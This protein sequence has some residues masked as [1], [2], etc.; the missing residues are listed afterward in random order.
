MPKASSNTI[1]TG[2]LLINTGT[3]ESP[4][5]KAVKSYLANF[6]MDPRIRPMSTVFWWPLLHWHIL[7]Q[8]S[9]RSSK[10]YR[11]I[12]TGSGF[13]FNDIHKSLAKGLSDYY[14]EHGKNVIVRHAMSYGAPS[15]ESALAEL[16]ECGCSRIVVLPMYPQSAYS[17]TGA[18]SDGVQKALKK[19]NPHVNVDL[20]ENYHDDLAYVRAVAASILNAGFKPESDDHLLFSYHSIPLNDIESGDTYELQTGATS[21]AIANEIGLD[22]NRWTIGY[23]CRF[24]KG[25]VWLAPFTREILACWAESGFNSRVFVVCPNFAVD[26]LETTY[27]LLREIKPEY[28]E[29][30]NKYS[31]SS[32]QTDTLDKDY[33]N[34]LT[35]I[36]NNSSNNNETKHYAHK[37]G[38][39]PG[40]QRGITVDESFLCSDEDDFVY[41]PCLNKSKAH[42]KVLVHVLSSYLE[43][44]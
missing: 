39:F 29:L 42:L 20:I 11:E 21:M 6:L 2:V 44:E 17:S 32:S 27:D 13:T 14:S 15:I 12:W 18:V 23:Q 22:R 9:K 28:I 30:K 43:S 26:C 35:G 25:R 1:K 33:E 7:P 38:D 5:Q 36:D 8:R 24:D 19:L 41:V 34:D 31:T 16:T 10:K 4:D 3:P 40:S 37:N